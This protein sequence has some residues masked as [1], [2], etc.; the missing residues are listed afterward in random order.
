VLHHEYDARNREC[1]GSACRQPPPLPTSVWIKLAHPVAVQR[2]TSTL[3]FHANCLKVVDT[4]GGGIE[5]RV[6]GG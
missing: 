1:F 3:N 5:S 2:K 6:R 4:F